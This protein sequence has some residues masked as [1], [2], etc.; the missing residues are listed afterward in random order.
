MSLSVGY[1]GRMECF[2]SANS[3]GLC[4]GVRSGLSIDCSSFGWRVGGCGRVMVW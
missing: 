4:T 2:A 1:D 3:R